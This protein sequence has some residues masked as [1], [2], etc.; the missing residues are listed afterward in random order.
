MAVNCIDRK[1]VLTVI[2]NYT[3]NVRKELKYEEKKLTSF[4]G[5]VNYSALLGEEIVNCAIKGSDVFGKFHVGC[6]VNFPEN[7][8]SIDDAEKGNV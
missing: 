3:H 5:K 2:F 8:D 1:S 6:Q 4:G 7:K